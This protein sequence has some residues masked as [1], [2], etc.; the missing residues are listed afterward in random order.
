[1]G[2]ASSQ[3][4]TVKGYCL[5]GDGGTFVCFTVV[6]FRSVGVLFLIILFSY[7]VRFVRY[8]LHSFG[9]LVYC[10]L[11]H[12]FTGLLVGWLAS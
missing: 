7:L 8:L 4:P 2:V 10:W 12:R 6:W 1:M 3:M 11:V 9:W 5:E